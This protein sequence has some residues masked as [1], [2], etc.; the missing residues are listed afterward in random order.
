M[1][2]PSKPPVAPRKPPQ[3]PP[4]RVSA[5]TKAASRS[6]LGGDLP[7]LRPRLTLTEL[8]GVYLNADGRKVDEDGVLLALRPLQ[9]AEADRDEE[10]LGEPVTSPAMLLKRVALDPT[11]PMHMRIAA[12]TSAAPYYDR[13]MPVALEGGGEGSPPIK[14]E[15]SVLLK[16]L[17]AL[18]AEDRKAALTLLERL[19]VLG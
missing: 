1:V 7:P 15:H 13:K 16:N 11:L 19:G 3:A 2:Q 6:L 9:Q 10:I 14:T 5:E 12:A 8:P 17:N 4:R 18:S